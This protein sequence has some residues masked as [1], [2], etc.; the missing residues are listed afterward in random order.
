MRNWGP[1]GPKLPQPWHGG[2]Y[3][4][5]QWL[6]D[7]AVLEEDVRLMRLAGCNVMSV[8]I[9]AWTALEPEDGRYE[10]GWLDSVVERLAVAGLRAFRCARSRVRE[11][12]CSSVIHQSRYLPWRQGA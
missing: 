8:A 4:P 12:R 9:F 2:D 5:D 10:F 11:Q 7:P 1:V 3:N 6:H